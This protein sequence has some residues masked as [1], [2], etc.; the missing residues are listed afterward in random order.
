M[1]NKLMCKLNPTIENLEKEL[2]RQI[3]NQEAAQSI[4]D[5]RKININNKT[6]DG[7]TLLHLCLKNNKS[8][9]AIWLIKQGID[10]TQFDSKGN[11]ALRIAVEKGDM[12][13]IDAITTYTNVHINEKDLNGRS[14][15]QDAVIHG[16]DKVAKHLIG[17]EI[18]VNSVDNRN[19]NVAFDAISY[20]NN[21][22]IETIITHD[23]IDLNIVD[24]DGKTIMHNHK[25]LTND[26]LAAILLENGADPTICDKEGHSFLSHTALR[27]EAAEA[28]LEVALRCGCDI[29]K[30]VANEN[31]ILMEVMFAF[32]KI[33]DSEKQRRSGLKSI[34]Q[35]LIRSGLDVDAINK[36]GE[37]ALFDL[38]KLNDIEGCAFLLEQGVNVNQRNNNF[39][40]PLSIAIIGGVLY[41][42]L[43]IL[44]LQYGANPLTRNKHSQTTLEVLNDIILQVH[45]F[46]PLEN[47]ELLAKIDPTGNY[48]LILKEILELKKFDFNYLDSTSNPLFFRPFL[49]GDIATT[50]LYLQYGLNINATNKDGHSLF[51]EYVLNTFEEGIYKNDFREKLVFLLV[52]NS[53]TNAINK[54]GQTIYSKVAYLKNC[55]L[56]LFRKLV[57]VTRHDYRAV[58]NLGR[59]IIHACVWSSN[60]DLLN[61]VYGVERNIQNIADKFNILPIIYAALMGN[62]TMV[63]E[64]LKRDAII[65][66]NK[67]IHQTAKERF[68]PM[69][70][71]LNTLGVDITNKDCVRKIEIL[72]EQ[73]LKDFTI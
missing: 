23:G 4:L 67:P 61:L 54:D 71:N 31:S 56:Q 47:Q 34:A 35:K 62:T 52:N 48:M 60:I 57:E 22:M 3:F 24:S 70:T 28:I 63:R 9:A 55:N 21:E 38:I 7:Q 53:N 33:P 18:D 25:V 50:K 15:L 20:G 40:T 44:L 10:V 72:R 49:N 29:N 69:L 58:D 68:Q 8:K 11:S 37:N 2:L 30:K 46:K 19:R 16:H 42:D 13:V 66:S 5:S 27:G 17:K 6:N 36:N 73:T 12:G 32:A 41:L 43:I 26:D 39:E 65:K 45:N 1:F 51:Y 64:F 14:L 59:T